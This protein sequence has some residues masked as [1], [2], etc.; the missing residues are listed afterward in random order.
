M[1]ASLPIVASDWSGYRDIV[2][3]GETGLLTK[4]A[5]PRYAGGA[6][7]LRS[8][9]SMNALD[10]IA[11][12]TAVDLRAFA[13]AV[14]ELIEHRELRV[15]LGARARQRACSEFDWSTVICRYESL[16]DELV[17]AAR[18]TASATVSGT[19]SPEWF[20][21]L[22]V[23]GHYATQVLDSES[24]FRITETGRDASDL[25]LLLARLATPSSWFSADGLQSILDYCRDRTDASIGEIVAACSSNG[26]A[27][28]HAM[29][30]V[31]RLYKYGLLETCDALPA[32]N[33][34]AAACASEASS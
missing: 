16:F 33:E 21:Y 5:M 15:R 19:Q 1:A 2:V 4:T 26:D 31:F 14:G 13:Q 17:A 22:E 10:L 25:P 8:S 28:G 32:A 24:R 30:A 11:A 29:S 34:A 6:D 3:P 12:T 20:D 18:A 27:E 9:G 23:F 7:H